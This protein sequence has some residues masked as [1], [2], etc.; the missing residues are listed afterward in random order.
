MDRYTYSKET[1]NGTTI[2]TVT[3]TV[4][5]VSVRWENGR[6]ND[7]QQFTILNEPEQLKATN[8][9]ELAQHLAT[10][11]RMLGDY[12]AVHYPNTI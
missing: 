3:D 7:S 10:V 5:G 6:F 2:H 11:S 12:I 4:A 1:A 9:G 8:A